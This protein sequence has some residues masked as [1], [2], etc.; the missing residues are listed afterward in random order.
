MI[1]RLARAVVSRRRRVILATVAL[2]AL[3][4][5]RLPALRSDFTLDDLFADAGDQRHITAELRAAFGN[6]DNV[7]VAV[8]E[9]RDVLAPATLG[10]LAD[11]DRRAAALDVVART[12]S[13]A[14]VPLLG[15]DG[16][17]LPR[18]PAG[19]LPN[20]AAA[21]ALAAAALASP[22]VRGRLVSADRRVAVVAMTLARGVERAAEL[23]AAVA[24]V[25]ALLARAPP[26]PGA[27]V[28]LAGLPYVRVAV[29][30][31]MRSDQLRLLPIGFG[32]CLLILYLAF[33]WPPAI[34]FPLLTVAFAALG[35][36]GAMAWLGV[37]LDVVNNIVPL[38]VVIIGIS[39]SIHL[40]SRYGEELERG[41]G[42]SAAG[43]RAT[44]RIAT[45]CFLTSFTTAVG[46]AS[47]AA[48][49]TPILARFGVLAAA[50]I[51]VA[52]AVTITFLPAAITSARPPRRA[53]LGGAAASWKLRLGALAGPLSRRAGW[54]V[55]AFAV[56]AVGAAWLCRDLEVDEGVRRQ[57]D[58]DSRIGRTMAVLENEL[59][60][61]RPLE[62][63][64]E[65][66]RPGRLAEPEV[67]A[68]LDAVE[69]WASSRPEVISVV[70]WPDLVR[71][72]RFAFAGG[73]TPR[74]RRLTAAE[75]TALWASA[76][77]ASGDRWR[78]YAGADLDRARITVSL[79]DVGSRATLALARDLER[80][81]RAALAELPGIHVALTGEGYA[82]SLGLEKL[83]RDLLLSLAIA[84]V[85]I[86]VLLSAVFRSLRLGLLSLPVNGL[87]LLFGLAYMTVR[88]IPLG[89]AT[90][91]V[92]SVA[93]GLAVDGTIHVIA[94][95][96]EELAAS[97]DRQAAMQRALDGTGGAVVATCLTLVAGFGILAISSFVPVRH[98]G[99]LIAVTIGACLV[100]QIV[101]LPPL[102]DWMAPRSG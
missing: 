9:A 72:A 26:P 76:L 64:V 35:I 4:A 45:A 57:F 61:S 63:Y 11:L 29:L 75:P 62:L 30:R 2:A 16:A 100:S 90:A 13:V 84:V 37:A 95:Y 74:L 6:T 79:A 54:V 17:P 53:R 3:A 1:E 33:R 15:A 12:D 42:A 36:V 41:G 66:D 40:I 83:I 38:L 68:A 67:L 14:S 101:L 65:A 82:S 59:A 91:I 77:T 56:A 10:Y 80:R 70:G 28:S 58:A 55:A 25:E 81:A 86:L 52:F 22:L 39:D 89:T 99:E 47:L 48:S 98:F 24:E 19:R 94:R 44:A 49:S 31:S 46:F 18:P 32:L 85:G 51:L 5:V 60:G 92:F 96:R 8:V 97:A 27:S 43:A 87:P 21:R 7:L 71:E 102:L 93:L 20:A 88:G 23:G 78:A 34:A 69:G 73:A 50:G